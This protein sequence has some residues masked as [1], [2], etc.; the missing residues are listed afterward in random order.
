MNEKDKQEYLDGYKKAKE[1]GVQFFPDAIFKDAIVSLIVFLILVALS[2]FVG[3]PL[4]ERANPS[5]AGYNPRPEWYFM[6][7]FQLLKYFPG[8]LEVIGVVVLPSLAIAV[9]FA[10]PFIDKSTKRHFVNRRG[11]T[12]GTALGLIAIISLTV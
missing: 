3:V 4:E 6:F 2:Y 7:L 11:I 12:L 9:L 8:E 5:D 1:K 10:L